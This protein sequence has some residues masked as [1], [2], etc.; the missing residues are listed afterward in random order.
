MIWSSWSRYILLWKLLLKK[1]REVGELPKEARY[2]LPRILNFRSNSPSG[3]FA[4]II[5]QRQLAGWDMESNR[6]SSSFT[7]R[8]WHSSLLPVQVFDIHHLPFH[9]IAFSFFSS[10]FKWNFHLLALC[11]TLIN[12]VR[13]ILKFLLDEIY[14][15]QINSIFDSRW[16]F[17][18]SGRN[19]FRN[20]KDIRSSQ[21]MMSKHSHSPWFF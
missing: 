11:F 14:L 6:T 3:L 2:S 8:S 1:S 12:R 4:M 5:Q 16:F 21:S 15:F 13:R 7:S 17:L 20:D 18:S 19:D 10:V 9:Q